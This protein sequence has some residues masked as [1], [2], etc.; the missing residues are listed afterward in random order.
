MFLGVPDSTWVR[1]L[2]RNRGLGPE[3]LCGSPGWL[4]KRVMDGD[5]FL[6]LA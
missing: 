5:G 1:F 3:G 2:G 6:V 4:G